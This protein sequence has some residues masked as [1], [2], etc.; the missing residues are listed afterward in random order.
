MDLS[1]LGGGSESIDSFKAFNRP[2]ERFTDNLGQVWQQTGFIE[3]DAASYPDAYSYVLG[4][5]T[6]ESFSTSQM[7]DPTAITWDGTHYWVL[8]GVF[9]Q[10]PDTYRQLWRFTKAGVF[11][12]KKIDVNGLSNPVDVTFNGENLVVIQSNAAAMFNREGTRIPITNSPE[13]FGAKSILWDGTHYWVSG[14]QLDSNFVYTGVDIGVDVDLWDGTHFWGTYNSSI[15]QYTAQG[16]PTGSVLVDFN[17]VRGIAWDGTHMVTI[18]YDRGNV[19]KYDI[20]RDRYVGSKVA[21]YMFS[22]DWPYFVRIK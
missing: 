1:T 22:R 5:Y 11:D 9:N 7:T 20:T 12:N 17:S 21:G 2:D 15:L 3:N 10:N 16:K 19:F 14:R 4:F 13:L 6:G 18:P 8:C